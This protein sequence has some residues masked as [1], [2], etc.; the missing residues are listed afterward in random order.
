MLT[1]LLYLLGT[2]LAVGSVW[3]F[4]IVAVADQVFSTPLEGGVLLGVLVACLATGA[5]AGWRLFFR[6]PEA[7]L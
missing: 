6:P 3:F 5:V 4:A 7:R 2:T 1:R